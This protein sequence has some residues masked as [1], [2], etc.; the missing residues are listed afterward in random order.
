MTAL[1][2]F[3]VGE[4]RSTL[5]TKTPVYVRSDSYITQMPLEHL[6]YIKQMPLE[7]LSYIKQILLEHLSYINQS[8]VIHQA[9]AAGAFVIHQANAAGSFIIH[10]ANVTGAF[11]A[12]Q[13]NI[14]GAFILHKASIIV[15]QANAAGAFIIH[16]A[17]TAGAFIVHRANGTFIVHQAN[18]AETLQVVHKAE[19]SSPTVLLK[20]LKTNIKICSEYQGC[21]P[22]N[23]SIS[24]YD[25]CPTGPVE[26]LGLVLMGPKQPISN[27]SKPEILYIILGMYCTIF[28]VCVS[29]FIGI[30]EY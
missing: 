8:F 1:I 29:H 3:T 13:A 12:C 17:N 24:L 22:D 27:L 2:L 10:Q 4:L 14:A 7:H 15:H 28:T 19:W 18:A 26:R 23:H 6:S 16:Q 25:T 30:L 9:N 20:T 5:C 21:Q 11:I